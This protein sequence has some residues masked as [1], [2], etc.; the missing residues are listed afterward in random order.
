MILDATDKALL[1][2]LQENSR[3]SVTE[4]AKR[5]GV[6]RVTA[7]ERLRRL[8]ARKIVQGYTVRLNPDFERQQVS[9]LV[10]I[11]TDQKL[12]GQ[13]VKAV[14][15]MAA[16]K[17]LTSI[18]GEYD[19]AAQVRADNTQALDDAIDDIARL[20]AVQRTMTSVILSTKFERF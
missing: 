10:L 12:S 14:E 5:L 8:E 17:S 11:S 16:V 7:Q 1:A 13:M 9:A 15:K 19:Y 2:L 4:L 20:D 18:S 3:L 6:S